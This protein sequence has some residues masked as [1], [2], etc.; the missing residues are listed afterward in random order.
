M[1]EIVL[2]LTKNLLVHETVHVFANYCRPTNSVLK[3]MRAT[4]VVGDTMPI[5][6]LRTFGEE[7][8]R[9]TLTLTATVT[10]VIGG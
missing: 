1:H 3:V 5:N 6:P 4:T 2:S 7:N 9:Q 8:R 10:A